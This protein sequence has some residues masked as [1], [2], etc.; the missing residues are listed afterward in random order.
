MKNEHIPAIAIV[1]VWL[2]PLRLF[3]LA[4][5][6]ICGLVIGESAAAAEPS[7]PT[8]HPGVLRIGTY[9]VNPPFEYSAGGKHVGF[10]VDLMREVADR[11][12]LRPTFVGTR[13]EVILAQMEAHR[14][15]CI[16]GGIT[17]TPARQTTLDYSTPYV[18]TTLD[19]I[20]NTVRTPEIRSLGDLKDAVVGV[21]AATTDYDAALRLQKAEQIKGVRVYPFDRI[22]Q[23]ITDLAAGRITAVMKV[24]PVAVWL[25]RQTPGLRVVAHVPD[26]P[27]PLG[28]GFNKQTPALVAAVDRVLADMK[29]DGAYER[30]ARKWGVP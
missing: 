12:G 18:T 30:L 28:I 8:L 14:Y 16:V 3:L 1:V 5:M 6:A 11:L 21:Q 15:D 20:V 4:W 29:K 27:Q 10:E 24:H 19:I 25:A 17:I 9:F 7:L 22:A 23:A 13:W 26:D 2:A